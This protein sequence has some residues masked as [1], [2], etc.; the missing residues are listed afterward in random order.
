MLNLEDYLD[1][2]LFVLVLLWMMPLASVNELERVAR[3]WGVRNLGGRLR[4]AQS[5][6]LVFHISCGFLGRRVQRYALTRDGVERVCRDCGTQPVW[7]VTEAGLWRLLECLDMVETVY[8]LVATLFKNAGLGLGGERKAI[9]IGTKGVEQEI[10]EDMRFTGLAWLQDGRVAALAVYE[11]WLQVP[12]CRMGVLSRNEVLDASEKGVYRDLDI[13]SEPRVPRGVT[14]SPATTVLV[15]DDA[16]GYRSVV[17]TMPV[18]VPHMVVNREGAR[19]NDMKI[20]QQFCRLLL[21]EVVADMGLPERLVERTADH[22]LGQRRTGPQAVLVLEALTRL[23]AADEASII[24]WCGGRDGTYLRRALQSWIGYGA[25]EMRGPW[26]VFTD[27]GI[28]LISRRYWLLEGDVRDLYRSLGVVSEQADRRALDRAGVV[29]RILAAMR[30]QEQQLA[31]S[32]S[33]SY[34]FDA[35]RPNVRGSGARTPDAW[36]LKSDESGRPTPLVYVDSD[37]DLLG[38]ILPWLREAQAFGGRRLRV[39]A[40]S[41]RIEQRLWRNPGR[42]EMYTTTESEVL[43]G[44][45]AG[46]QPLWRRPPERTSHDLWDEVLHPELIGRLSSNPFGLVQP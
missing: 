12:I 28:G 29:S 26:C 7:Q 10:W 44:A 32:L 14:A 22:P 1:D 18:R 16:I 8:A 20:Y 17:D 2:D 4:A 9:R 23:L 11:G 36:L 43:K 25:V 3:T 13:E 19:F 46:P 33:G 42:L 6:C 40:K 34:R 15:V 31:I 41:R 5:E 21:P 35:E 39:V 27:A 24:K 38:V 30:T 37:D 45:P